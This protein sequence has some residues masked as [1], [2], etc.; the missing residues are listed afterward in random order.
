MKLIL[1]LISLLLNQIYSIESLKTNTQTAVTSYI[2]STGEDSFSCGQTNLT[3]C[4]TLSGAIN[5]LSNQYGI[6]SIKFPCLSTFYFS[7]GVYTIGETIDM[8][9]FNSVIQP[10]YSNFSNGEKVY[11]N[12]NDKTG[13]TWFTSQ[14]KNFLNLKLVEIYSND[15]TVST[16]YN[17]FLFGASVEH[18][19][20]IATISLVNCFITCPVINV[21]LVSFS[22]GSN[23]YNI[24]DIISN[25]LTI[26]IENFSF[27]SSIG[28][29]NVSTILLNDSLFKIQVP[30]TLSIDSSTISN[31]NIN[32]KESSFIDISNSVFSISNSYFLSIQSVSPLISANNSKIS[33]DSTIIGNSND[34]SNLLINNSNM[35]ELHNTIFEMV[36]FQFNVALNTQQN[37]TAILLN[38]SFGSIQGGSFVSNNFIV[39]P[40]I[41]CDETFL[42]DIINSNIYVGSTYFASCGSSIYLSNSNAMVK[43]NSFGFN[44]QKQVVCDSNTNSTFS[45]DINEYPSC[46]INNQTNENKPPKTY[47]ALVIVLSILVAVLLIALIVTC[48]RKR[49]HHH[50]YY[51]IH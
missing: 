43:D 19:N 22:N 17:S 34:G 30:L 1:L 18:I 12:G 21:P 2:S 37:F 6:D 40:S 38:N 3:S 29:N 47:I 13:A 28:G 39:T 15:C 35:I 41:S 31:L 7:P 4:L 16:G 32:S 27:G 36:V 23:S 50:N 51:P 10:F 24:N 20:V 42:L 33:I 26:S 5:S 45:G 46:T 25:T 44:L 48:V 8:D 49:K 9:G 14:F 11:F